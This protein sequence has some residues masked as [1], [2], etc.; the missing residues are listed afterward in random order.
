MGVAMADEDKQRQDDNAENKPQPANDSLEEQPSQT[1]GDD[2]DALERE[3]GNNASTDQQTSESAATD[4]NFREK[5]TKKLSNINP[6][7]ALF[8]LV[9]LIGLLIAF[10]A[11]RLNSQNDPA[12][13][14]FEGGELDQEALDE[15]LASE[16]NIGTV[17]QTL[18]V[19]ANA[20]FDGKILVRSDLDVAGTLRV[21]GELNVPGI[22]VAGTSEFENV[23]ASGDLA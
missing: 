18:T 19:A 10:I 4:E 7:L 17:D 3:P 13:I 15:L 22:A 14:A 1:A 9:L 11:N 20:I 5:V 6:Y 23:N 16:Q 2:V 12:N 21:G 8:V